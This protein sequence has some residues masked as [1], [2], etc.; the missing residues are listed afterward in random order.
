M[1]DLLREAFREFSVILPHERDALFSRDLTVANLL[2]GVIGRSPDSEFD[3]C[4]VIEEII[5]LII[6]GIVFGVRSDGSLRTW[7]KTAVFNAVI[8]C[9]L[10]MPFEIICE[11]DSYLDAAALA[12]NGMGI[13]IFPQ[14]AYVPNASLCSK[15]ID[16]GKRSIEYLFVWLKG[17]PLPTVEEEFIDFVRFHTEKKK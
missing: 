11:M 15:T 6:D 16:S 5:D 12:G 14:T 10:R 3:P 8:I 2:S 13:S 1:E 7:D 17:H 4:G 9:A